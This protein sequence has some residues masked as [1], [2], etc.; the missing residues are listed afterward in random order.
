M[1]SALQCVSVCCSVS[2]PRG[3]WRCV[4][5]CCSVLQCVEVWYSALQ[6]VAV[7]RALV[8]IGGAVAVR[9]RVAVSLVQCVAVCCSVLLHCVTLAAVGCSALQC[10]AVRCNALQCVAVRCSALQCVA[11]RCRIRCCP[12]MNATFQKRTSFTSRQPQ[13]IG[14]LNFARCCRVLQ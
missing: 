3:C 2:H 11:V 5:V 8:A 10:V 9:F 13:Q 4:A 14:T 7:Y 1:C 12:L 6:C